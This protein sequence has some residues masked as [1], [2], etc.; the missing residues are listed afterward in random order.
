MEKD[1]ES[2][3]GKERRRGEGKEKKSKRG[4]SSILERK[5]YKRIRNKST[6][7]KWISSKK[8]RRKN[9]FF[10]EINIVIQQFSIF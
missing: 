1:L 6:S 2:I 4:E 10:T 8:A 7:V 9:R 3:Q 5:E